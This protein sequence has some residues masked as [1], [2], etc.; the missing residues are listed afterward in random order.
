MEDKDYMKLAIELAK[1]GEG[2]TSPNP[3]VGAVIVK[4]GVIIGTGYHE[5]YGQLHAERNAINNAKENKSISLE[6]STMYVTLEPCCHHGKTPPCTDAIIENKIKKV[7]IGSLDPNPKVRGKGIN[8]LK[9]NG[10]EV[11]VGV[12]KEETDELNEIFFNYIENKN[13]F[14]LLKYAMTMDGKIATYTRKSKW[15]SSEKSREDAH[16]LR[17]KYSAIMVGVGTVITDNPKLTSRIEN[18]TNPIRVICDSY[19]RCPID[20]EVITSAKEIRT[21]IATTNKNEEDQKNYKELGCEI[22]ECK[23]FDG[24]VDL[25]D[26]MKKLYLK[27][28]D[29]VLIEGGST[30]SSSCFK[31]KIVNKVRAYIAPKIFG[32]IDAKGPVGGIGVSEVSECTKLKN[33][34]CELIDGDIVIESKVIY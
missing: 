9:E 18:S 33:K 34:K 31:Q 23:V 10:I 19:L 13:P 32:G 21:I 22:I 4:N 27:G 6:G 28:I 16:R 26:L 12:L 24:N 2:K 29:S 14:V 30:L 25:Q 15:I 5:K 3:V 11:E 17:N 20:R 8:I 7:V 1:K